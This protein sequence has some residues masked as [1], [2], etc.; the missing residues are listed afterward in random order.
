VISITRTKTLGV[1]WAELS[2]MGLPRQQVPENYGDTCRN[3]AISLSEAPPGDPWLGIR[4]AP[5][6]FCRGECDWV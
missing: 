2:Q 4:E 1:M 5:I 6:S 3:I